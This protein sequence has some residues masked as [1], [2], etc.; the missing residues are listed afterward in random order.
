MDAY[1][2]FEEAYEA[3]LHVGKASEIVEALFWLGNTY[4]KL[5]EHRSAFR[6]YRRLVD[7]AQTCSSCA[8]LRQEAMIYLG[9]TAYYLGNLEEACKWYKTAFES[10]TSETHP[11]IRLKAGVGFACSLK[12]TGQLEKALSFMEDLHEISL[13]NSNYYLG[14]IELDIG[15]FLRDLN[16]TEG[17]LS[18]LKRAYFIFDQTND[19]VSMASVEEEIA[20]LYLNQGDVAQAER[21]CLAGMD[22]VH[23]YGASFQHG[24]LC[25]VMGK[26]ELSKGDAGRAYEFLRLAAERFTT[27]HATRDLNETLRIMVEGLPES[28]D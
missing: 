19:P 18:H 28:M 24:R 15:I 1:D 20:L 14:K 6:C 2:Q 12:M 11:K 8:A 17:A 10:C 21:H 4:Y 25:R 9:T 3:S 7:R 13:Q 27:L 23:D 5:G 16:Q 22:L 26:I